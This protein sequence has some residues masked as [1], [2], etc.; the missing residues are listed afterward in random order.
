MQ[1]LTY[2]MTGKCTVREGTKTNPQ[3]GG[4]GRVNKSYRPVMTGAVR[5]EPLSTVDGC[6]LTVDGCTLTVDGCTLDCGWVN[7]GC[8]WVYT[9]L[10]VCGK[11][12][13]FHENNY[14]TKETI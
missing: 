8:G 13:S 3:G 12:P 5:V 2:Y 7:T 6:T 4:E 10:G 9:G 14:K 1:Q 11:T